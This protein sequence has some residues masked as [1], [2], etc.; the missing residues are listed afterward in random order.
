[1]SNKPTEDKPANLATLL[2][3][4]TPVTP[5]SPQKDSATESP[6]PAAA[7]Y[8]GLLHSLT[9]VAREQADSYVPLSDASEELEPKPKPKPCW[10]CIV[11]PND[12]SHPFVR[13]FKDPARLAGFLMDLD[14][15]E[16]Y[17]YPIYG[18]LG[19]ISEGPFRF[20]LTHDDDVYP[21]FS[22]PGTDL[23]VEIEALEPQED[24]YLGTPQTLLNLPE[25]VHEEEDEESLMEKLDLDDE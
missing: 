6:L 16:V 14:Q 4:L 18:Y 13:E 19:M 11:S 22:P 5:Q 10:M 17:A 23:Q 15:Q 7:G 20:F 2:Q 9:S 12:G 21:L 24:H 3:G 8:E 1:M 25:A